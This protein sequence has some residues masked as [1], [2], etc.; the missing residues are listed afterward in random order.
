MPTFLPILPAKDQACHEF[1]LFF[2]SLLASS[3]QQVAFLTL[4]TN[5]N[6]KK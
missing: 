4:K 1:P 2:L 5:Q 6:K 3:G